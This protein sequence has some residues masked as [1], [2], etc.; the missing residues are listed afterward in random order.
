MKT[1]RLSMG[2]QDA[3]L[4]AATKK[5][6]NANPEKSYPQDGYEVLQ[7]LGVVDKTIQTQKMFKQIWTRDLP[8]REIDSVSIKAVAIEPDEDD[9]GNTYER[10][11]QYRLQCPPTDVPR[12]LASYD[13]LEM[14]V[15]PTDPTIVECYAI[16]QYNKNIQSKKHD[17]RN[18]LREVMG[19]FSTLNQLLKAA[20]YMQDLVPNEKLQKMHEKDDRSGRRAELAQVAD[21][22]LSELRETL[23]E[24]ALLGDNE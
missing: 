20:P 23:L 9:E 8:M 19:R 4:D 13:E 22:E 10:H 21:T 2:L 1:V 5:F 7:R 6:E 14:E 16:E 12:F 3:I 15:D 11:L 17:Y 18:K 24:D